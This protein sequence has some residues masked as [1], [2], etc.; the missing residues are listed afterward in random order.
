VGIGGTS[1]EIYKDTSIRM[2]PLAPKDVASMVHGLRAHQL[3]EGYRGAAPINSQ[4]LIDMLMAFS[5]FVMDCVAL[6]ESI[7]LNPVK[8][9]TKRCIVAD[10]RI[11]LAGDKKG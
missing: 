1:V 7:D 5:G 10:A 9:S 4:A 6:I 2:A 11:M 8:C 3:L